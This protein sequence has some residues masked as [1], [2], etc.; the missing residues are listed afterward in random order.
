MR[1]LFDIF[2]ISPLGYE[3]GTTAQVAA[4]FL[5]HKTRLIA[6]VIFTFS[7]Q[8][9]RFSFVLGASIGNDIITHC[10]FDER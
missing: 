9:Y 6:L 10:C 4:A 3:Y 8:N 5:Q 1:Y 2:P 7:P